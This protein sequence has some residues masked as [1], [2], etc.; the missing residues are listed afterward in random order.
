MPSPALVP[1]PVPATRDVVLE[2]PAV[3]MVWTGVGRPHETVAVPGVVL[4]AGETLVAI[5]LAT[6][7]GSD[8]HTV[9]GHRSAPTPLVLGHEY[10]GRVTEVA[11]GVR[12]VDGASVNVGDRIVWSIM[13]SCRDCDR[14]RRGLPQKCRGLLKYGHERIQPRWELTGGFA[15]HAHLRAGTAIVRVGETL[16]A[17]VLAPAACGTAT[18]WAALS[19][20]DEVADVDDATVLIL[21]GGLI[22]LTACAMARQRG[23]T[24][25]LADP[26]PSRRVLAARF[27]AA[28]VVDPRDDRALAAALAATGSAEFGIVLEASGAPRAVGTA[29]E[30]VGVGGVVVLVGS[31]FPTEPLPVDPERLVRGLVTIRGV[32]NYAPKDLDAAVRYLR[33]HAADHP[34]EELVSAR[35]PLAQIDQALDA[36]AAGAA[37]RVAVDPRDAQRRR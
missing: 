20:A 22:G 1:T 28:Q 35:Y 9:E 32:H 34:F 25:V 24:V 10:V 31:V 12:A 17:E 16:R 15:T 5:E 21:G 27:G 29:L 13:A 26:D 36:A 37:V 11:P 18:A 7:C 33:D 23:A 14:C 8:V 2:P 3:A 30:V 4:G 6:V 19:R